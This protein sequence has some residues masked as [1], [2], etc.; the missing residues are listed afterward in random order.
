MLTRRIRVA[1]AAILLVASG[2]AADSATAAQATPP[3]LSVGAASS[4]V[5]VGLHDV[6][7]PTQLGLWIRAVDGAFSVRARR[8]D[9]R[10]W[11]AAQIDAVSGLPLR[12]IPSDLISESGGLRDFLELRFSRGSR[13]RARQSVDFCP[14]L[15]E[16]V[17]DQGAWTPRFP[18]GL[19][20]PAVP[21]LTGTFWGIDTGWAAAGGGMGGPPA[22]L[23]PGRYAVRARISSA[24]RQ[25]FSIPLGS[26]TAMFTL[27]VR[28]HSASEQAPSSPLRPSGDAISDLPDQRLDPAAPAL[29]DLAALP[30]WNVGI[31]RAGRRDLL[32]FAGTPWNA[33]PGP[34]VVEGFRRGAS[35]TMDARQRILNG[36]GDVVQSVPAGLM[37]FHAR[38]GHNHWHFLQFVSYRLVRAGDE[39]VRS[40][41][42]SF[43]LAATDPVDVTVRGATLVP[44]AV[45]LAQS[46]CGGEGS[47]WL[48]QTLPAG[49]GDTYHPDV[50]GQELDITRVPNGAYQL[51][52]VVNPDGDL[53]EVSIAN[54]RAQRSLVLSGRRGTRRVRVLPWQGI[55]G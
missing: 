47:L 16:R 49:W 45:G 51:E 39:V 5:S 28:R 30:A 6:P 40:R 24:F 9:Y 3:S 10:T 15:V 26:A 48:R 8:P 14:A 35:T 52:M 29:P 38:H 34:L 20:Q 44:D 33:G 2:A 4:E 1:L 27:R 22:Q 43:C 23:K 25:L 32:T 46:A 13:T 18:L 19:C 31:R 37:A 55:A 53:S 11:E 36:A 41:K 17:D 21:F 12:T 7:T 54:N 42:Q 50:A